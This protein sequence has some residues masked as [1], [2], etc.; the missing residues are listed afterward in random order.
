MKKQRIEQGPGIFN[1][2][3]TFKSTSAWALTLISSFYVLS[4][5]EDKVNNIKKYKQYL[6]PV[7]NYIFYKQ[8][9]ENRHRFRFNEE[10][11]KIFLGYDYVHLIIINQI[12]YNS[13]YSYHKISNESNRK[14][15][16]RRIITFLPG[17]S[18]FMGAT[19]V[20]D[21]RIAYSLAIALEG[22]K[23][24]DFRNIEFKTD[25]DGKTADQKKSELQK[26]ILI[27]Y[28]SKSIDFLFILLNPIEKEPEYPP[29]SASRYSPEPDM[30][31]RIERNPYSD[32][33]LNDYIKISKD[34]KQIIFH[35]IMTQILLNRPNLS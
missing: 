32:L 10:F 5:S 25:K 19:N 11:N 26:I 12:L 7:F 35:S 17:V 6:I 15:I 24:Y 20:L 18:I 16:L 9:S 28:I 1:T 30:V 34:L 4:K 29:L 31:R 13:I 23:L 27:D 14:K 8:V 3:D 2:I 33:K 21:K 22:Y